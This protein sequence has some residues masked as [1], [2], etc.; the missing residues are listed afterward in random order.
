VIEGVSPV[1]DGGD[2]ARHRSDLVTACKRGHHTAEVALRQSAARI[3]AELRANGN[4]RRLV[5]GIELLRV[6]SQGKVQVEVDE[7]RTRW[8]MNSLLCTIDTEDKR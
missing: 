2:E 8:W 6:G 7:G 5:D 1:C 3:H 4:E